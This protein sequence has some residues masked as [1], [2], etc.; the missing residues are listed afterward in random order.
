MPGPGRATPRTPLPDCGP[1]PGQPAVGIGSGPPGAPPGATLR[2]LD[3]HLPRRRGSPP[4]HLRRRPGLRPAR[5][6]PCVRRPWAPHRTR[7]PPCGLATRRTGALGYAGGLARLAVAGQPAPRRATP[8]LARPADSR[9]TPVHRPARRVGRCAPARRVGRCAPALSETRQ[10]RLQKMAWWDG[11]DGGGIEDAEHPGGRGGRNL[12]LGA[13]PPLGA[14]GTGARGPRGGVPDLAPAGAGGR[15][16]DLG[17]TATARAD[18]DLRGLPAGHQAPAKRWRDSAV[19][20]PRSTAER[21]RR[22]SAKRLVVGRDSGPVKSRSRASLSRRRSMGRP[23]FVAMVERS[24]GGPPTET[25]AS[26]TDLGPPLARG[27]LADASSARTY[28]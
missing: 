9:L 19:A 4:R 20:G 11:G 5:D 13:V 26:R 17:A 15:G 28:A 18:R 24:P 23:S 8:R 25:Y 7:L 21:T 14:R 2:P 1:R 16:A 22:R 3:P 27:R 6:S 10:G 12:C